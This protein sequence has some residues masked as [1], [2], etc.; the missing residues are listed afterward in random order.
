MAVDANCLFQYVCRK[1]FFGRHRLP[2]G[3][4]VWVVGDLDLGLV[5]VRGLIRDRL[6][7]QA[8][9]RALG[10]F[11]NGTEGL[12]ALTRRARW[13]MLDRTIEAKLNTREKTTLTPK[14]DSVPQD[15]SRDE[16]LNAEGIEHF[17]ISFNI[18]QSLPLIVAHRRVMLGGVR[19]R[20]HDRPL[21]RRR[22]PK[23][24]LQRTMRRLAV[25]LLPR[26]PNGHDAQKG[27]HATEIT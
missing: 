22:H 14:N 20:R 12:S 4:A 8:T 25:K 10:S 16:P 17:G 19:C 15:G 6:A 2:E 5:A 27:K 13:T 18:L 11:L 24:R 9:R 23:R 21:P 7:A 26:S 3:I 1:E